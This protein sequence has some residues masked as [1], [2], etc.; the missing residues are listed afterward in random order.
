MVLLIIRPELFG[1]QKRELI[2]PLSDLEIESQFTTHTY[3]L[4]NGR[5]QY[6]KGNDH[7][8][9]AVRCALM[10]RN[11]FEEDD[12]LGGSKIEFITPLLT[13]PIFW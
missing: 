1:L 6:S 7:I 12:P 5:V 4:N 9:D 3:T 2:F 8:I 11:R 10:V 13:D